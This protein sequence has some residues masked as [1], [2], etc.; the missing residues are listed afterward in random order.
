MRVFYG[1]KNSETKLNYLLK[2]DLLPFPEAFSELDVTDNT[3]LYDMNDMSEKSFDRL[4]ELL[5]KEKVCWEEVSKENFFLK[6]ILIPDMYF[7]TSYTQN[8]LE[9]AEYLEKTLHKLRRSHM[10]Y[11]LHLQKEMQSKK[12]ELEK[13]REK[14]RRYKT[15]KNQRK[16]KVLETKF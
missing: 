14:R 1:N 11:C 9:L 3:D 7:K 13:K 16:E 10:R 5:Q 15:N 2:D 6:K 8:E 12:K 4:N